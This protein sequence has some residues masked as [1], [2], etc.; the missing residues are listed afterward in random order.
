MAFIFQK[1]FLQAV[2]LPYQDTSIC[3]LPLELK[4]KC[5]FKGESI[6]MRDKSLN[7]AKTGS[8]ELSP[9]EQFFAVPSGKKNHYLNNKSKKDVVF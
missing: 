9:K 5:S 1:D 8:P 7:N 2:K 6:Q 4:K 3:N